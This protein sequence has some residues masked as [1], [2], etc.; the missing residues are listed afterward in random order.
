MII[1][2]GYIATKIKQAGGIDPVTGFPIK[3]TGEAYTPAIACQY[4]A[5]N[6]NNLGRSQSGESFTVATYTILIEQQPTP[7]AAEQ[8]RLYDM[9]QHIVGDFSI[10]SAEPIEA[11][12]EVKILV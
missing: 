9:E 8:I 10:I 1:Q 7:F 6:H 11:A 4:Y 2:N 3:S 12:C 5:N